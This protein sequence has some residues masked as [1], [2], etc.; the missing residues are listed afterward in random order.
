MAGVLRHVRHFPYYH[1]HMDPSENL[2]TEFHRNRQVN[3]DFRYCT[4]LEIFSRLG[5]YCTMLH[6]FWHYHI[7]WGPSYNLYTNFHENR[8]INED[9][10][11]CTMLGI[12]SILGRYCTILHVFDNTILVGALHKTYIPIFIKIAR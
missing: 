11:Y 8:S 5:R 12:F 2:Y 6:V 9:F 4:M 10:R 7:C 1:I 3:K